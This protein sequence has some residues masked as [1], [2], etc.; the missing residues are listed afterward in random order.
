[1]K[2]KFI[3][4]LLF[5]ALIAA[6]TSTFVSCAKD[7][8]GDI[9][10]LRTKVTTNATD[11]SSLVEEKVKNVQTEIDALKAQQSALEAA[12]KAADEALAEAIANATNDAQGYADI[13]AAEAQRAAIA[14]AQ[15]MVDTAVAKLEES[16]ETT[17][18]HLSDLG[19]TVT[20]QGQIIDEQGKTLAQQAEALAK[21]AEDINT[22]AEALA[23]QQALIDGLLEADK[24]LN[25]AIAAAQSRADA[26]YTLAEQA[27]SL[28]E[29][30]QSTAD[31]NKANIEK[32]TT[33]LKE[34]SDGLAEVK[35][36]LAD[37]AAKLTTL[38]GDVKDVLAKAN[39]NATNI[40]ALTTQLNDLKS[41]NEKA[42]KS[43]SDKDDELNKLINDNQTKIEAALANETKLREEADANLQ[44]AIDAVNLVCEGLK[45]DIATINSDINVIKKSVS[46]LESKL[47]SDINTLKSDLTKSLDDQKKALE[48]AIDKKADS[49]TVD[50]LEKHVEKLEEDID[51]LTDTIKNL[52]NT[53]YFSNLKQSVETNTSKIE[54][55]EKTIKGINNKLSALIQ[56]LNNLV[57]GIIV[58]DCKDLEMLCAQVKN[59]Q[60]A[61]NQTGKA[62]LTMYDNGTVYFPYK[63]ATDAQTLKG[64]KYNVEKNIGLI[65]VTLNPNTIDF[66]DKASLALENS[67]SN[68]PGNISVG[69]TKTASDKLIT[70]AAAKNGLYQARLSFTGGQQS[71]KPTF[72]NSYALYTTY[73]SIDSVGG[74]TN[75]HRVYSKYEINLE[76]KAASDNVLPEFDV[77]GDAVDKTSYWRYEGMKGTLKLGAANGKAYA[78]YVEV[79]AVQN[80]AKDN[81]LLTGN[82]FKNARE[83]VASSNAGKINTVLYE[84]E[85]G[86][87]NNFEGFGITV[88]DK[89]NGYT[90]TFRYYLQQY[91]GVVRCAEQSIMFSKPMF[92]SSAIKVTAKPTAATGNTASVSATELAKLAY[93]TGGAN[94]ETW[95]KYTKTIEIANGRTDANI[96]NVAFAYNNAK[97]T[98]SKG[99]SE[100]ASAITGSYKVKGVTVTYDAANFELGKEYDFN[101]ISKDANG[102][103][104]TTTNVT[105]VMERP[106]VAD[107][108]LIP[109]PAYAPEGTLTA[110]ADYDAA[111]VC[112]AYEISNAFNTPIY[113]AGVW[114]LRLDLDN[115]GSYAAGKANYAYAPMSAFSLVSNA[116]SPLTMKVPVKALLVTDNDGVEKSK[117]HTYSILYGPQYYGLDNLWSNSYDGYGFEKDGA[118]FNGAHKFNIVFKSPIYYAAKEAKFKMRDG[119]EVEYPGASTSIANSQIS[120]DDPSTST[121]DPVQFLSSTETRVAARE[122]VLE[123]A[124]YKSL[125]KSYGVDASAGKIKI[126]TAEGSTGQAAVDQSVKFSL[127][128]TDKFGNVC[129]IPFTVRVKANK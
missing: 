12:Y 105:F 41:S 108:E 104:V 39:T 66:N 20:S 87:E 102:N 114:D 2:R 21:Q 94:Y 67:K 93:M 122:V 50:L 58:Q 53:E 89:Y 38:E 48:D 42:L 61:I 29:A 119:Y 129:K 26:A 32:L 124:Q 43:L 68:A 13:Q 49:A 91:D 62:D 17:K 98:I 27:K 15:E 34:T 56:S 88:D 79:V 103:I 117:E 84:S 127:K 110:W 70:R 6:S 3:S 83:S 100:A 30:A 35:K 36:S 82:E 60:S 107:A 86:E 74:K 109:N 123:E 120:S 96:T 22:Q 19:Q 24:T 28:A 40:E 18:Q 55:F 52:T 23:T 77:V 106:T 73:N 69:K 65:Y 126:E 90:F 128:V 101:I 97:L 116:G 46:D 10:E 51:R 118:K 63:G 59:S 92:E 37:L 115:A 7:Y 9:T 54:E 1:M 113:K 72:E 76:A 47:T 57:T 5:G 71:N 80:P 44:K 11:L 121:A 125:F 8:D 112:G 75:E 64:K 78:K 33:S 111:N 4:A 81:A 25:T 16:L 99:G 45:G 85:N 95:K 31:E 14:A